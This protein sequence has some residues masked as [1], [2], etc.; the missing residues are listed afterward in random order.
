MSSVKQI[1][2]HPMEEI[3]PTPPKT[4]SLGFIKE[5]ISNSAMDSTTHG[6]PYFFRRKNWLIRI[7]WIVCFLISSL[8]CSFMIATSIMSFF[9]YETVTKA[10]RVYLVQTEFPTISICNINPFTTNASYEFVK[11]ELESKG[12]IDFS[13]FD[14]RSLNEDKLRT[15]K[16]YAALSSFSNN[17]TADQKKT[18]GYDLNDMLVSCTYNL[19]DCKP[20]DFVW[21]YDITFGNCYQFN[22]RNYNF[23]LRNVFY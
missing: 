14:L 18:L 2:V 16:I 6:I 21:F 7:I 9:D 20:N 23:N 4:R 10:E 19:Y 12:F 8:I 3:H 11:T 15:L 22:G 1:K 13:S 17:L 5:I